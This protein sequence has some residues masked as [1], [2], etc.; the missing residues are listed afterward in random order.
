MAQRIERRGKGRLDRRRRLR[1]RQRF[2]SRSCGSAPAPISAARKPRCSKVWRASAA[3]CAP[4]RRCRRSHGLFGKPTL[5]NNVLSLAAVPSILADGAQAYAEYGVGRSRGTLP[6]QL[7]GN[8]QRGGLIELAFGV[9]LRELIEDFGGGTRSGGRPRRAGRRPARRL[10]AADALDTPLDYEAFAAAMAHARPRRDRRVRRQRR[11]GA[12]WR[13]S[14]SN[15]APRKAAASARPAASAPLRGVETVDRIIAGRASVEQNIALLD[16]LCELMTDGSLCAM[17]GLT[18]MPVL[19]ARSTIS[20]KISARAAQQAPPN[21]RTLDDASS[22]KSTTA[23]RSAL[24]ETQVTL[25]IDGVAGQRARRAPR[26]WRAAMS[27]ARKIPKLCATDTLEPFGSCRLCLV[28]I[29]GRKRHAGLLHDAGRRR[30]GRAH[31]DARIWRSCAR[32]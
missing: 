23:R 31:A 27:S 1:S 22:R 6:F 5:I 28:E 29:E 24:A 15:S 13:A 20:R 10:S 26:S 30:H 8:V 3:W 32:A 12:A 18:P 2:S 25:T 21:R 4:S 19:S 16:D 14:P 17:G 7:G 9:T 11:H